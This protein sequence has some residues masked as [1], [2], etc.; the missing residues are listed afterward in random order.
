M[1]LIAVD[2][3]P[4]TGKTRTIIDT[5]KGWADESSAVITYTNDAA[6]VLRKRAA[7][8]RSG[9]IYSLS[10]PYVALYVQGKAQGTGPNVTYGARRIHHLF[11]PALLQYEQDA[12]SNRPTTRQDKLARQLHAWSSGD[13]PFDLSEETAKGALK[14]VLPLARW[15]AA[16]CP[17]P[18]HERLSQIAIDEAQDMSWI[19]LRA[20]LGLLRE[21]GV[22][23]AYGDPGQ[24][25]FGRAKG[26]EGTSL[27]P[28]WIA[29]D[30]KREIM[31]GYRVG[32][33]AASVAA[34]VLWSY[35]QRPASLFKAGHK[36]NILN[37]DSKN[38]PTRGLAMGYSRRGVAKAF[39]D[40]GLRNTGIV[41]NVAAADK[42]LVLSTG[43]AAKGAEADD[44]YL[45]P[46]SRIA[47][48]RFEQRNPETLRLLYVMLTRA[49]KRVFVPTD[50]KAR[51]P[52]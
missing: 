13:P 36:T 18:E 17:V 47:I 44:I 4:G 23:Y 8:L 7:W 40:W 3:P 1:Q 49:R 51:L 20:T 21:D 11:D 9:T 37:W 45:L 48:E 10:W 28:V 38:R 25:I 12:P 46:W 22:A 39:R 16:G 33:P 30:E 32:D 26:V 5:A 34:R 14:F 2:G 29:A 42:E 27:P 50:L 19:E 35:Y 6:G 41:P 15:V 52:L 43:H 31:T 24:A